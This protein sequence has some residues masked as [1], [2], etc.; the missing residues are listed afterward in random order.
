ML[1]L[2]NVTRKVSFI[3]LV[4]I[5]EFSTDLLN[6]AFLSQIFPEII[7]LSAYFIQLI[8]HLFSDFRTT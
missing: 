4:L 3:L 6:I 8:E 1:D 2:R 7:E 5:T